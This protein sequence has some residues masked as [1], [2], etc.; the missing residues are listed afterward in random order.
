MPRTELS[1]RLLRPVAARKSSSTDDAC[2]NHQAGSV[3][4]AASEYYWALSA[5]KGVDEHQHRNSFCPIDTGARRR[6]RS[7]TCWSLRRRG[8]CSRI[9][10]SDGYWGSSRAADAASPMRGSQVTLACVELPA[11]CHQLKTPSGGFRHDC[12]TSCFGEQAAEPPELIVASEPFCVRF[13]KAFLPA[14]SAL[15]AAL[16]PH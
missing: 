3:S 8:R 12:S 15:L 1:S 11:T 13:A 16:R 10:A 9:A 2:W 14:L 4:G 7:C 5:G 6:R